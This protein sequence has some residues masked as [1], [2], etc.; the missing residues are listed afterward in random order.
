MNGSYEIIYRSYDDMVTHP[1][2]PDWFVEFGKNIGK[3][4]KTSIGRPIEATLIGMSET[5]EDFY[6]VLKLD[7]GKTVFETCVSKLIEV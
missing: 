6:Y 3:R 5:E 7:N 2:L 1:E 4:Y